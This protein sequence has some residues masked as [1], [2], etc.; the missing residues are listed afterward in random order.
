MTEITLD[1]DTEEIVSK[2]V[3]QTKFESVEEYVNFVVREVVTGRKSRNITEDEDR[4]LQE[5]LE[6]LGYL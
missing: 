1:P 4:D 3:V 6:D 5:Q 2:K